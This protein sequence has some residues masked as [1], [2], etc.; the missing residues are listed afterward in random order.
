MLFSL[1]T[2]GRSKYMRAFVLKIRIV[3]LTVIIISILFYCKYTYANELMEQTFMLSEENEIRDINKYSDYIKKSNS[4]YITD[5]VLQVFDVSKNGDM[6]LGFSDGKINAYNQNGE[7]I[8]SLEANIESYY[9]LQ[10]YGDNILL[11]SVRSRKI[12]E[13]TRDGEV[14]K[15]WNKVCISS[16]RKMKLYLDKHSKTINGYTYESSAYPSQFVKISPNGEQQVIYRA[17]HIYPIGGLL[18]G[19]FFFLVGCHLIWSLRKK[20][21]GGF[22]SKEK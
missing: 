18:Y 11:Y 17:S 20:Y 13:I 7:F 10:F 9:Y 3:G 22:N 8:F 1:M 21:K 4:E 14:C 2:A 16:E 15:A 19:F 6:I 12:F 5:A